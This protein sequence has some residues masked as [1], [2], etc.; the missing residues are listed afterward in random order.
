M[1]TAREIDRLIERIVASTQPV[2]VI[3]FGSYAKGCATIRSDLDILVI[4]ET[5][6][7]MSLRA[8]D[9]KP[10]LSG[11]LIPVDVHIYTPEEIE[12][13]AAEEFSFIDSIVKSGKT[14]FSDGR[15]SSVY[16]NSG[17]TAEE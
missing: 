13:Y 14:V 2:E 11:I 15:Y 9:L 5:E 4:K 17:V 1:L 12:V 10:M 3:I 6:L 16:P 8:D 7:P